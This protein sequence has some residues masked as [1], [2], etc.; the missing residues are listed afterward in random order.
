[1]TLSHEDI[2]FYIEMTSDEDIANQRDAYRELSDYLYSVMQSNPIVLL[3]EQTEALVR[4]LSSP[5]DEIRYLSFG[6][7]YDLE[8][9]C[10]AETDYHYIVEKLEDSDERNRITALRWMGQCQLE[11]DIEKVLELIKNTDES[12]KIRMEALKALRYQCRFQNDL[13]K[14]V[15]Y[16]LKDAFRIVNQILLDSSPSVRAMATVTMSSLIQAPQAYF[17]SSLDIQAKKRQAAIDTMLD[18]LN[19][20]HEEVRF[21]T[22]A[23]IAYLHEEV[24]MQHIVPLL[25]DESTRVIRSVCHVIGYVKYQPAVPLLILML[26]SDDVQIRL[27]ALGAL[28]QLLSKK[29]MQPYLEKALED[30]SYSISHYARDALGIRRDI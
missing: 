16:L 12:D 9:E 27:S 26:D 30:E 29:K 20:P 3:E 13:S 21:Q 15:L 17:K 8:V 19:D 6:T 10:R 22:A 25:N 5:D 23:A 1:M 4:G 2:E 7:L 11:S 14:Q 24:L 28:N 18:M